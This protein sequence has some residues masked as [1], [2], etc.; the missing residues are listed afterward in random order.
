[1]A[2]KEVFGFEPSA[3]LEQVGGER[4]ECIKDRKH[5]PDDATILPHHANSGRTEFSERTPL[6]SGQVECKQ[7][8]ASAVR[9]GRRQDSRADVA[10]A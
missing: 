10:I 1:M 5:R 6:R 4:P 2:E 9:A 3:R 7:P 8:L